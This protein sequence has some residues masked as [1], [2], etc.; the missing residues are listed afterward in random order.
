MNA[1]SL[2][3]V[4]GLAHREV[5]EGKGRERHGKDDPFEEQLWAMIEKRGLDFLR[6]QAVK[7]IDESQMFEDE[8]DNEKAIKELIGAL[9]YI[10]MKVVALRKKQVVD[11]DFTPEAKI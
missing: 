7:K 9:N 11:A 4:F 5:T 10:G 1:N 3:Y 8:G 2:M 6:G